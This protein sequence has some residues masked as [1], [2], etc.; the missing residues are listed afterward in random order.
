MGIGEKL[1]WHEAMHLIGNRA[2][3]ISTPRGY[4]SGFYMGAFGENDEVGAVATARH[5]IK[6]ADD[7][8]E[9][10]KLFHMETGQETLLPA[11]I[12]GTKRPIFTFGE[13]DLAVIIFKIPQDWHLPPNHIN[14][15]ASTKHIVEGVEVGWFGFPVIKDDKLCFFHG[16]VSSY[17]DSEGV[18]LVDGVSINGVSGGPLFTIDPENNNPII[19]G[20]V[21]SYFPNLS[22]GQPLPGMSVFT[23]ISPA[24]PILDALKNLHDAAQQAKKQEEGEITH[25]GTAGK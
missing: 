1:L 12:D 10:I 2:L 6:D 20:V 25:L 17:L 7:W 16:Y 5:V 19:A 4:G 3:K 9:P 18:Y 21:S 14:K 23:S 13:S 8:G 15:I 11:M 22:T 24:V